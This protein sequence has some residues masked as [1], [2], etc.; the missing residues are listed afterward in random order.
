MATLHRLIGGES[1]IEPVSIYWLDL[2]LALLGT[3][4]LTV[5]IAFRGSAGTFAPARLLLGSIDALYA[6]GYVLVAALFPRPS[7]LDGTERAAASFALSFAVIPPI[8]LLLDI[9]PGGVRPWP[10]LVALDLF[11]VIGSAVAGYRR[12]RLA[13][14]EHPEMSSSPG[15]WIWQTRPGRKALVIHGALAAVLALALASLALG[16]LAPGS[17][18]RLSEFYVLGPVGLARDYPSQATA[19]QPV[20]VTVGIVNHEGAPATYR[21]EVLVGGQPA[22]WVGPVRLAP[23]ARRELPIGFTPRIAGDDVEVVFQLYREGDTLPD[24][25][26]RLWLSVVE[27]DSAG[28]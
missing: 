5:F 20:S 17:G 10:I 24:R 26:L 27:P 9:L 12:W 13:L 18:P 2:G 15:T 8:A 6:P 16:V 28:R 21:A 25:S 19:G 7:D 23:G 4:G 3:L 22:G 14:E 11:V 1:A